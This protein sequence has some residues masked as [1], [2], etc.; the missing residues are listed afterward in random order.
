M[1]QTEILDIFRASGAVLNGHFKL[2]SGRHADTYFEKFQV[3]QYPHYVQTL[4]GEIARQYADA[5]VDVVVGPTT[6]GVVIAYEVA[7]QLGIRAVYAEREEGRRVLRRGFQIHPGERVLVVDDVLTT[8]LS[9]REVLEML[10]EWPGIL[11]GI[12]VLMDRSNGQADLGA[13]Y[14]ALVSLD[15][16]SW[17]ADACPLCRQGIALTERGS[18]NIAPGG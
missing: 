12:S 17:E 11:A 3:L 10:Q 8:G 2:S 15:V 16:V 5:C 6:G 18:R 7:R 13:P 9:V 14:S 1:N 4:C